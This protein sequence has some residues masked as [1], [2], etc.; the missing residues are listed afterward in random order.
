MSSEEEIQNQ[1]QYFI[2]FLQQKLGHTPDLSD[3]LL[4]IG[5]YE[6]C[7]PHKNFTEKEKA[8]LMQMAICTILAPAKYYELLWVDD[9]GWSHFRQLEKVPEMKA[10]EQEAFY[11]PFILRYAIKNKWI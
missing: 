9:T 5:I 4:F 6:A 2:S 10:A 7:W 1:W 11:R 8:D 3:I